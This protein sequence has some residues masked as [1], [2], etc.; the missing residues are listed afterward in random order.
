VNQE[1]PLILI[2]AD[3][4]RYYPKPE[5]STALTRG[6]S[7]DA[8]ATSTA[9]KMTTQLNAT[10]HTNTHV[11]A[12][13]PG[14]QLVFVNNETI[15]YEKLVLACGADV[16]NPQLKGDAAEEVLSINHIYHYT[17]FQERIKNKKN[18]AILGAGLI[19]CEFAND[20]G[21]AH[22][23]VH[24]IS[25]AKSP[26]DLLIPEKIGK[27]L[28][29]ALEQNNVQ[30]HFECTATRV[31]KIATGYCLE[32][33]NGN[34]LEVDFVLSAIGLKPHTAL[35]TTAGIKINRGVLVNRYL[36]TS[37]K[38]I[39]A[40]GDCAEVHVLPYIAPI[41]NC[42]RALGKTLAGERTAVEYPAMPVVVKTPAHPIVVCP[43][44]KN[45]PGKWEIE[46]Q[47]N[48][49]RALF[50]NQQQQL[51]GF[52]LTNETVKERSILV[53]QMPMMF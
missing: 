11:S 26:L 38:N 43:P 35:A 44:P 25:P 14:R 28:Q 23:Q 52:I 7:S 39:Y 47:D 22:Y 41:L 9:E 45:M 10:I 37:V 12:I 3:D 1:I 36:E 16:I 2:T 46:T 19:G 20:L 51:Y 18:I 17:T 48:S 5:I 24:M 40:L 50:Y 8:I 21:N 6:K 53:R 4:G 42:S 30:F 15:P 13:D 32:L 49:I 27:I 33:S 34:E 29:E 31:D